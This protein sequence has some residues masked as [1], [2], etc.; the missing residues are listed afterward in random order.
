MLGGDGESA[1]E[2][3]GEINARP[4]TEQCQL[5]CLFA[6]TTLAV[7]RMHWRTARVCMIIPHWSSLNCT[8][9]GINTPAM[10][11]NSEVATNPS[12]ESNTGF[13][14]L[15]KLQQATLLNLIH[16]Q[17]STQAELYLG[18]PFTAVP[19]C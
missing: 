4:P 18:C 5:L 8:T 16:T 11:A 1:L 13:I 10:A 2:E 9:V 7:G 12:F 15:A 17:V 3:E 14:Q 6:C 19:K